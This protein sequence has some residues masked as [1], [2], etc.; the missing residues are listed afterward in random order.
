MMGAVLWVT[1]NHAV[2]SATRQIDVAERGIINIIS[3]IARVSLLNEDYDYIQGHIEALPD[4]PTILRAVLTDENGTIVASSS[5]A[6][7]GTVLPKLTDDPD[8][9]WDI[10]PIRNASGK[11]GTLAVLFSTAEQNAI[12]HDALNRG[13]AIAAIGMTV[14]AIFSIGFGHL[15]TRRLDTVVHAANQV[16][17]GNYDVRTAI[18]RNDEIGQLGK[19]FDTMADV[20]A[21]ERKMLFRSNTELE[22]RIAER[23]RKLVESNREYEAF[24]YAVSHD[25]RSPLRTLSGFSDIL[26]E[27]YG[28]KLD[29]TA[30]DHLQ[31]ISKA[32]LRMS[33]LI[34]DLLALSRVNRASIRKQR[35]N[36]ST[37]CE[38]IISELREQEPHRKVNVIIDAAI[39]VT[40]DPSLLHDAMVNLL[41][42]A[43]KF[44]S[45]TE[46]ACIRFQ[47]LQVDGKTVYQVIDNG[48]GFNH[49]YVDKLFTPF[50]RLHTERDFPGTGIG[51]STVQR[52]IQRHKGEIRAQG[53]PGTGAIFSFT[54]GES[55]PDSDSE[56]A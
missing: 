53:E 50:Q 17:N 33:N 46:D 39:N 1:L 16:A 10:K 9:H 34:D 38:E 41:Q 22:R 48:A 43:W 28:D 51:L 52:I 14:I 7:L 20:I 2:D 8:R 40:G 27:D 24:A 13:I 45:R 3:N 15:L 49:L 4:N 30:R 55:Y 11:L 32:S 36:L 18:H 47:Q 6:D 21:E 56:K 42:N 29:D 35:V 25:L 44:T 37:M 23:T 19:A 12:Y 26:T 31:R 54:L 5:L